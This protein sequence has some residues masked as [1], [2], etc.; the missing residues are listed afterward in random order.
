MFLFQADPEYQKAEVFLFSFFVFLVLLAR[1]YLN[2][3]DISMNW[4]LITS[5]LCFLW[6]GMSLMT[7]H[8]FSSILTKGGAMENISQC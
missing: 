2:N 8:S 1:K 5:I 7:I 3:I 6:Y 4:I